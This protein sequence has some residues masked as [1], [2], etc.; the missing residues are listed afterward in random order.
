MNPRRL[1]AE[2]LR[3]AMLAVSGALTNCDG[4]PP[5]WPALPDEVLAANPAFYDDNAEKTKGWYPSPPEALNV[6]SIY[7]I[8]KRSVRL[9]F[10]ETFDLPDN[11]VTCPRRAVSTVAPQAATLLNNPFSVQMAQVFAA[12]LEKECGGDAA[13]CVNMAWRH[14]FG[15]E[16]LE[17]ESAAA[18]KLLTGG[19]LVG[20]S[21]AL[22][23]L[24][25]FLYLD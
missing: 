20:F 25:E 7:L 1:T 22:L 24:N 5:R 8:Q 10:M 9:P 16:P 17:A 14:T 12:R 3:D 2:Q 23:N 21:R 19:T 15:R 18:L 13:K 11:F 4:G 6:R